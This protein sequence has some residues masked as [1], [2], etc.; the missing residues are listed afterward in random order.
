MPNGRWMRQRTM[1]ASRLDTWLVE[2]VPTK[3]TTH[4]RK[5]RTTA[6]TLRQQ[7]WPHTRIH[8]PVHSLTQN[9]L[10]SIE[11]Y[12]SSKASMKQGPVW[13]MTRAPWPP[14]TALESN[15]L[16]A[17]REMSSSMK[18]HSLPIEPSTSRCRGLRSKMEL[19]WPSTSRKEWVLEIFPWL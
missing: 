19:R 4:C 2:L 16:D 15:L 17:V 13:R 7:T 11:N 1:P 3:H 14:W 5:L 18:G 12:A 6:H 9:K 8:A 10:F